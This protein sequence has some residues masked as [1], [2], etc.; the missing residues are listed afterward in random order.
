MKPG[1]KCRNPFSRIIIVLFLVPDFL[2]CVIFPDGNLDPLLR[3]AFVQIHALNH[4]REL[5][6]ADQ[7][8]KYVNETLRFR[9]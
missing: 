3:K 7:C 1:C 5:F 2:T 6:G 8:I 9:Y 4:F